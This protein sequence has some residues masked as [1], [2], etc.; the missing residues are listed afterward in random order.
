[1]QQREAGEKKGGGGFYCE[2]DVSFNG[3]ESEAERETTQER[4]RR[5]NREEALME[6]TVIQSFS[7]PNNSKRLFRLTNTLCCRGD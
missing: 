4:R 7:S 3:L 6:S 1:M 2:M 5:E